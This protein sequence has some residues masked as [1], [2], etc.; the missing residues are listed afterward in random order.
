MDANCLQPSTMNTY[1]TKKKEREV[2][3]YFQINYI[4]TRYNRI[5]PFKK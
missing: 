1:E 3:L 5:S 2:K 4:T